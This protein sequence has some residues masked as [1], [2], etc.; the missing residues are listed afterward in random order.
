[1]IALAHGA[2]AARVL[3]ASVSILAVWFLLYRL[4][5]RA[6]RRAWFTACAIAAVYVA[7]FGAPYLAWCA[8]LVLF[9]VHRYTK[10]LE[11][12]SP[13]GAQPDFGEAGGVQAVMADVDA[14]GAPQATP[15]DDPNATANTASRI[16][17]VTLDPICRPYGRILFSGRI[18]RAAT[19]TL[20]GTA[21]VVGPAMVFWSIVDYDAPLAGALGGMALTIVLIIVGALY[22]SFLRAL[23]RGSVRAAHMGLLVLGAS[24]GL[25]VFAALAGLQQELLANGA[26]WFYLTGHVL[27]WTLLGALAMG[28]ATIVSRRNDLTLMRMLRQNASHS[29]QVAVL[30]LCGVMLPHAISLKAVTRKA[31]VLSTLAFVIEGLAFYVYFRATGR[32]LALTELPLP[33]PFELRP[34]EAHYFSVV[35]IA[36]L[37]MP[38]FY[39]STQTTLSAAERM[40]HVARCAGLRS[41]EDVLIEDQ[42]APV[43]FLRGFE[44]DQVSLKSATMAAYARVVD[45]GITQANLEDVLLAGLDIGPVVAIGRPQDVV[46]PVGVARRYVH[47]EAWRDVVVSL[48]DR[49]VLIVVGV[50]ESV[51][52]AWELEQLRD[53]GHLGKSVFVIPPARS[54]DHRLLHRL[55]VKLLPVR[56]AAG[57]DGVA[58]ALASK[59]RGRGVAGVAMHLHA[60][61]VFASDRRLTQVELDATVRL[62][63]LASKGEDL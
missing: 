14:W 49:A 9:V 32:L 16:E 24:A 11:T 19:A 47:D 37:V 1:M 55:L 51:G 34:I 5:L 46:A 39:V 6:R 40:R 18:L 50:S 8:L 7:T 27:Q 13:G 33:F 12:A 63:V 35:T 23:W 22:F 42:R 36:C 57:S 29:W 60:V 54:R 48:M 21:V 17:V 59:V 31:V 52:V 3:G 28:S 10:R 2:G 38:V 26:I 41:A 56:D 58:A 15:P 45:P 25:A 44:D 62:A 4:C 53:R 43:L 61:Q 30:Q 20:V